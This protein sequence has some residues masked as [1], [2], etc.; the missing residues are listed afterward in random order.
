MGGTGIYWLRYEIGAAALLK[1]LKDYPYLAGD[2]NREYYMRLNA[3]HDLTPSRDLMVEIIQSVAPKIEGVEAADWINRQR[4]FDCTILKGRK[5]FVKTQHYP[6]W[7]EYLIFQS[8]FYY[9]TFDNGSE[10]AYWDSTSGDWVYHNLNGSVGSGVL[11]DSNGDILWEKSLLIE[12]TQNPP[13]YYGFGSDLIHLSTDD[14]TSPWPGGDPDDFILNLNDL[15]L[16][17][18]E[19]SFETENTE[20]IRVMGDPLRYTSGVFG[21]VLNSAGGQIYLNHEDYPEEPPIPLVRGAFHGERAWAS[22]DNPNTGYKDS[23]PGRVFVIYRDENGNTFKDQRNIDL[24]SWNGN[25]LFLFDTLTMTRIYVPDQV[26]LLSPADHEIVRTDS[27][28]FLWRQSTPDVSRY[29]FELATDS[30]MSNSCI[31]STLTVADTSTI[32]GPLIDDQT[33]WWRVRAGNPAGWGD[34]SGIRCFTVSATGIRRNN[35]EK[36]RIFDLS[37]NFPN[38]FTRINFFHLRVRINPPV[39]L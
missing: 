28:Q 18:L 6:G 32:K 15:G 19:L 39:T 16:Y 7:E 21:A 11:Y 8:I 24:G 35:G 13:D 23:S 34:F 37:Q 10:W 5:I 38:P 27:V 20:V 1:M 3:D 12:P 2:F 22:I 25:Q 14:D 17:R 4:I 33:Y 31:D 36:M 29:W 30:I 26:I 9:E